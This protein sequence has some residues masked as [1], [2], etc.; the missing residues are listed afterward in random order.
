MMKIGKSKNRLLEKFKLIYPDILDT[1]VIETNF[2]GIWGGW[3]E[4]C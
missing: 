2:V 1:R 4:L 3:P